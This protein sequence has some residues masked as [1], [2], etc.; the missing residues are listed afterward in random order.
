MPLLACCS[1]RA[2]D[3]IQSALYCMVVVV[4]VLI[5]VTV[6]FLIIGRHQW[7]VSIV[8]SVAIN[9][10]TRRS[11]FATAIVVSIGITALIVSG[12]VNKNL[13][14]EDAVPTCV[15]FAL[16]RFIQVALDYRLRRQ[17]IE[18]SLAAAIPVQAQPRAIHSVD[19]LPLSETCVRVDECDAPC[20]ICLDLFLPDQQLRRLPC[21]HT[22][23]QGC[24]DTWIVDSSASTCPM[25][26]QSPFIPSPV[27]IDIR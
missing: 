15:S 11:P 10:I 7:P 6:A 2:L 13:S 26:R 5:D 17:A 25:C 22:F 8:A 18:G 4:N 12:V 24:I 1:L 19:D 9:I 27:T 3:C 21:R 14:L 23:H 20:P 16:G